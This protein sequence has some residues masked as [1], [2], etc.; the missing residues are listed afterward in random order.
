LVQYG[1]QGRA[2]VNTVMNLWAPEKAE[3]FLI[4]RA[5]FSLSKPGL[6]LELRALN[7]RLLVYLL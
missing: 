4:N 3:N 7:T 6:L 1:G 2:L 5:I